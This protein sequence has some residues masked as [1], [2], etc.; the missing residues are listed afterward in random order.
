MQKRRKY[1]EEFKREAVSFA[2]QVGVTAKQVGEELGINANMI[3]RWRREL[4]MLGPKAFTGQGKPRDE[5]MVALKRELSRVKKERD[6]FKRSGGV[7]REGIEMRFRMIDRC[8]DA[9]SVRMMCHHLNVSPSGY[10]E[11]RGREPSERAVANRAL[12]TRIKKLHADSDGVL[13][14]P[15]I[16]EELQYQGIPCGENRVAR[17]MRINKLQGIPQKRRWKKKDSSQRPAGITNHLQRDFHADEQNTKWVTDITYIRTAEGWLYLCVVIDLHFGIVVGW[18]MSPRQTRDIVIQAVLMALWQ[19]ADRSPVILHSDRG[20]QFTSDEYQR[21]L[22]GH[23]LVSSMSAVGSCADN[24]ACE[25]FFGML[26]RE[27]V[28][29][30][31][32]QTRTEARA[33]VFDYIERFHNPRRRRR[34]EVNKQK[35]LSLT[36]LSEE[37]GETR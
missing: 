3:G 16:C 8:R 11:G 26:K 17:L 37:T 2:N 31:Q 12:L 15:R 9:Y 27:R 21:F 1:S 10:Y 20:C 22:T 19:R 18:S 36:N 4:G 30:R 14:A 35:D 13:G 24:A 32:Y 6:F 25:G 29:R 28:N 34:L 33:D 23:N 7:V 5:E